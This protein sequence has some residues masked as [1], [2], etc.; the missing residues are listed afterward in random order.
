MALWR[1]TN[2]HI[3]IIF[4]FGSEDY[5]FKINIVTVKQLCSLLVYLSDILTMRIPHFH[6]FHFSLG[7]LELLTILNTDIDEVII[8]LN[9]MA[10]GYCLF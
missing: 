5:Y 3:I 9:K 8:H 1:Y 10:N 7:H 4:T 2:L 6:F